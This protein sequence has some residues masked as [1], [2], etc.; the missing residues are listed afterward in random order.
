MLQLYVPTR[1][2]SYDNDDD[3]D[4]TQFQTVSLQLRNLQEEQKTSE[5]AS[6]TASVICEPLVEQ[7]LQTRGK[8]D[9]IGFIQHF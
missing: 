4:N 1:T 6:V 2:K 7:A 9:C 5:P 8:K 3:Y